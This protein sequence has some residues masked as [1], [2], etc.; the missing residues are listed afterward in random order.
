MTDTIL[1]LQSVSKSFNGKQAVRNVSFTVERGQITGFL[2]PNGAGKTTSLRM[3][4]GILTP[5][6]GTVSLFGG[7][8]RSS[9][10]DRVGFLPEEHWRE[11][12]REAYPAGDKDEHDFVF[13]TLHKL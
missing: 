13:R 7:P 11:A 4:L 2:G 12:G 6:S 10:L 3:S 8:P 9:A 5:D 1:S